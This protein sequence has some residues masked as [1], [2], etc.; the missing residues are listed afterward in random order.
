M[1]YMYVSSNAYVAAVIASCITFSLLG[2][3]LALAKTLPDMFV[4]EGVTLAFFSTGFASKL[5]TS[6]N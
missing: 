6:Y 2:A 4:S 3:V 5:E 1:N